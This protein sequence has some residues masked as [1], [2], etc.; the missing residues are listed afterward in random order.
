VGINSKEWVVTT[1]NQDHHTVPKP[2]K[3]LK[4]KPKNQRKYT[5]KQ[6][7]NEFFFS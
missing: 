6:A 1:R 5:D 3:A 7:A 2:K 4:L